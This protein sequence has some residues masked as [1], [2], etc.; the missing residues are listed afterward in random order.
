MKGFGKLVKAGLWVSLI[1]FSTFPIVAGAGEIRIGCLFP[2]SGSLAFLGTETSSGV[3]LAA[4]II[5]ERG[6]V[7]GDKIVLVKGDAQNATAATNECNRLITKEG[8]TVIIGTYA[9]GLSLPATAVAERNKVVYWEVMA[10]TDKVTERGFKYLF[11]TGIKSSLMGIGQVEFASKVL[12]PKFGI[13]PKKL[14]M[15]NIWEDSGYGSSIEIPLSARTKELG[16]ELVANESYNAAKATDFT[17]L[18]LK[19]KGLNIDVLFATSYAND[20]I[21]FL[22]QSRELDFNPK[23]IIGTGAGWSVPDLEKARGKDTNGIFNCDF[24]HSANPKGLLPETGELLEIF[25]KRFE[26]KFGHTPATHGTGG[27]LGGWIL[28]TTVLPQAAGMDAES[29]RK[30]ALNVDIPLGGVINGWGCKFNPP[31][32][33]DAGQNARIFAGIFQWQDGRQPLIY[34]EHLSTGKMI[35]V[36]LPPWSKR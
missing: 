2:Y 33:P 11:R 19:L 21:L 13:E 23:A 10:A 28:F 18:I 27:F 5:N 8:L 7:K 9:S 36:P 29:V 26:K 24:P 12:A 31:D 22:K 6:G 14:R 15:A 32:A 16:L 17:P 20:A 30:A 1:L 34:P 35:M 25:I 4:D 3:E